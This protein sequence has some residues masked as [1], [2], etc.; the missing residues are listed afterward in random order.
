MYIYIYIYII[1]RERERHTYTYRYM[2]IPDAPFSKNNSSGMRDPQYEI[3]M[4]ESSARHCFCDRKKIAQRS[5]P[6]ACM[7]ESDIRKRG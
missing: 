4:A 2:F 5:R 3:W 6:A 7:G 1:E